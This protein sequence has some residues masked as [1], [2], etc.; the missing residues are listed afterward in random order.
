MNLSRTVNLDEKGK[1]IVIPDASSLYEA[2][3][4]MVVQAAADAIAKRGRFTIALSG[5]STPKAL[6]ALLATHP[7]RARID[8]SKTHFFWGDERWVPSTD[9]D[10]NY[11]MTNEALLSKIAVPLENIHRTE[12]DSGEPQ[13]SA[14]KYEQEIRKFFG[15]RPQFDLILLGLGTNGHTASLFPHQPTLNVRDR[16]VVADY[17]DEVK[18]NRIT[19]TVPLINDSRTI[20]FL[21]SG[22]D[23]AS[24]LEDVLRGPRDPQRLPSQLI[25]AAEEGSLIW[26]ADAAAAADLP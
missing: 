10:S 17:I 26:L 11:R 3:A 13:E 5:G 4:E 24:V 21:A 20:L 14:A 1:V 2:A 23:K 9:K 6:Y 12:T 18:M 25:R 16:L 19:F 7:W 15:A 8:W 22:K